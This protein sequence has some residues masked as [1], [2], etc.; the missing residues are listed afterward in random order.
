MISFSLIVQ[1]LCYILFFF[2]AEDGIRDYKVTGV[3]TC[4]LP[5]FKQIVI[6]LIS[7]LVLLAPSVFADTSPVKAESQR[8]GVPAPAVFQSP[9]PKQGLNFVVGSRGLESF[10]FNGQSLLRSAQEGEL[11]PQRSGFR[12]VLDALFPRS[13][14]GVA[15]G[16][17]QPDTI[18]L[19]YRW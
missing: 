10:S 2:Q 1:I 6:S 13:S 9:A 12:A 17:K 11:Q 19:S 16:N 3:Q 4:A 14:S 18:D 15:M 8:N 5:I 7:L